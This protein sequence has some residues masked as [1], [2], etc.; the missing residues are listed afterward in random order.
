MQLLEDSRSKVKY[1]AC[2]TAVIQS[3]VVYLAAMCRQLIWCLQSVHLP[4]K[5]PSAAGR[6]KRF[7]TRICGRL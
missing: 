4:G 6:N 5:P 1:N 7:G 2:T 3:H